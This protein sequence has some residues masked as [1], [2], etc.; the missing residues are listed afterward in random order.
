[1][2]F[3]TFV[4]ERP[5]ALFVDIDPFFTSRVSNWSTW[6]RII[7][8]PHIRG[9]TQ[10]EQLNAKTLMWTQVCWAAALGGLDAFVFTAGI[11][12]NSGRAATSTSPLPG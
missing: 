5:D 9:A 12:E 7:G 6:R 10:P 1:M 2:A 3:A 4:R 8:S 11:G